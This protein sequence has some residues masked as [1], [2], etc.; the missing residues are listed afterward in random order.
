MRLSLFYD[1]NALIGTALAIVL[2]G[3]GAAWPLLFSITGRL[4]V[5][6]CQALG[7]RATAAAA[8]VWTYAAVALLVNCA[9]EGADWAYWCTAAGLPEGAS[10]ASIAAVLDRFPGI[11]PVHYTIGIAFRYTLMRFIR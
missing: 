7:L 11:A 8:A 1:G 9:S 5:A 10:C 6:G 2:H 3:T 4:L